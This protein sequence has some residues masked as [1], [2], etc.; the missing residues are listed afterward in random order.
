VPNGA[1]QPLAEQLST[2]LEEVLVALGSGIGRCQKELD[3]HSI[4]TQRL[5]DE[6]PVLAQYGL[7][8]TW[9]QIPSTELELKVAIALEQTTTPEDGGTLTVPAPIPGG[10]R[11]VPR[12][13]LQPIN[14]R[15]QNQFS[16]D[17]NAAS[18]IT[19]SV[20]AVPPPGSA[21]GG[22]PRMSR[23]EVLAIAQPRLFSQDALP[24]PSR[25]TVNFN[26]GARAWY[27]VQ[28][29][30]AEER[31]TLRALVKVDDDTGAIVRAEGGPE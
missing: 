5:I 7:E 4:E 2:P 8:A 26:A 16:Y 23:D 19:L 1:T 15:V 24:Q 12:I 29:V 17:V 11:P 3:R 18:T 28:T 6:D 31:V 30:E 9:Y 20:V 14:P 10:L 27:V 25:V 22:S 13:W 21:A